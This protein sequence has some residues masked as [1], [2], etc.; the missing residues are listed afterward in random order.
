[1]RAVLENV[2]PRTCC[3]DR[4]IAM[5]IQQNRGWIFSRTSRMVE[6]SINVLLYGIV[7]LQ[8]VGVVIEGPFWPDF[9]GGVWWRGCAN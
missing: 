1:M 4:A 7:H 5:S 2:Q 8:K 3:V 9:C 6:V